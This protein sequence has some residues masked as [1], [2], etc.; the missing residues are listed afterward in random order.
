MTTITLPQPTGHVNDFDFLFGRWSVANRRLMTRLVGANDWAEFPA[1]A[2]C[3]PRLGGGA[4]VDQID[5]PTLGFSGLTLR[6]FDHARRQWAIWW[7]NS[8]SGL[9][10]PPVHGGFE[11]LVGDFYGDDEDDGRAVDVRYRWTRISSDS[12]R[13]EQAFRLKGGPTST[14]EADGW[15]T[16]WVMDCTRIG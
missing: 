12:A 5:F 6:S 16:N 8:K 15:E 10:F 14:A 7:I 3:E 4:N 9:L 13:W 2:A 1:T 11:G